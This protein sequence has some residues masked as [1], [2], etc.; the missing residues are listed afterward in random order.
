MEVR[1]N[2]EILFYTVLAL[3]VLSGGA[4]SAIAFTARHPDPAR[5]AVALRLAKIAFVGATAL[6]A[7]L[8]SSVLP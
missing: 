2:P 1:M 3:T 5:M 8:G 6:A 7:L 4:A